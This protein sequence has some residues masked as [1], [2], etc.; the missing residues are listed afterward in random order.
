MNVPMRQSAEN[1]TKHCTSTVYGAETMGSAFHFRQG[2][3]HRRLDP[4]RYLILM[5]Q[6]HGRSA[7][8]RS[9]RFSSPEGS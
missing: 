8:R 6:F 9:A 2:L 7:W 5:R 1:R 4:G 3:L